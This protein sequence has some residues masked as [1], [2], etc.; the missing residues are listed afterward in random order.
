MAEEE[1]AVEPE[2]VLVD[3]S[4]KRK[5]EELEP[6]EPSSGDGAVGE[7]GVGQEADAENGNVDDVH[8]DESEAKRSRLDEG[9][10]AA[11]NGFEIE[12]VDNV[13]QEAG[14]SEGDGLEESKEANDSGS[15]ELAADG[16]QPPIGIEEHAEETAQEPSKEETDQEPSKEE[17]ALEPS[18]EETAQE[19]SK[20][21]S[22][23]ED[24]SE[25][26][27]EVAQNVGADQP[28][29][30]TETA[31][32][33]ME[34]PNN[35]VGVLIGKAGETIRYL[36]YNSGAKIQITRDAE[37]DR[38]S[39]SRSVELIG[40]L[41]CIAKAEKL[42]KDVIAEADAGGS[43]SLVARGFSTVQ[44]VTG[45][46]IEIQVPN[47]KVGLIIGKGGETIKNLQTT[48]GARIQLI[49]QHPPEG[50]QSEERTVRVTG[51]RKQI[52]IAREMIKEV[53]NQIW[54]MPFTSGQHCLG[55]AIDNSYALL[56]AKERLEVFIIITA[57]DVYVPVGILPSELH[58]IADKIVQWEAP[59]KGE[60]LF[61][62][63]C[64]LL[65]QFAGLG[66]IRSTNY[67]V[68][69]EM[70]KIS[71]NLDHIVRPSPL[72]GGHG[73]P[74]LR[75][76]GS[77][78]PQWGPQTALPSHFTGYD[79]HHR[80]GYPSQSQQY[81]PTYGNYPQSAP[82]GSYGPSWE[83]RPPVQ[84]LPPQGSYNYGQSQGSEYGQRGP[85][86][87][88][89][90]HGYNEGYSGP[91]Q[92]PYGAYGGS[93][94]TSYPTTGQYP[95]YGPGEQYGKPS[96]YGVP[97]QAQAY[98][99]PRAG[100]A[101][102]QGSVPPT[103]SYGSS[104][105]P[106]QSYPYG[107]GVP[108]QQSYPMYNAVAPADGYSQPQP[109]SASAPAY[110]QQAVPPATGYAQPGGQQPAVYGQGGA[111]SGYSSYPAQQG[112]AEQPA[113]AANAGYGYQ[114]QGDATYAA[115][116]PGSAAYAA[117]PAVQ[118]AYA[119]TTGTQGYDQSG[120]VPGGYGAPTPAPAAYGQ[121]Y[122]APR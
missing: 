66:W 110:T 95:G 90:G 77:L 64:S 112:Y 72:S 88:G 100:E 97:P 106:Q 28:D 76:R 122:A 39:T 5:L 9:G 105:P 59:E 45:D 32:R 25:S 24:G 117:Q 70:L 37:A 35:R 57:V 120:A 114:G 74:A 7:S 58:C 6:T 22:A 48:S 67:S 44:A 79:H 92:H 84:G 111:V 17:T 121:V 73:Q 118:A 14:L 47:E 49:P 54:I 29:G 86:P 1:L 87:R 8:K 36:Q 34:V 75:P 3:N 99:Q 83:Q 81:P 96:S 104:V 42:I 31:T 109:A 56:S 38:H 65:V 55:V 46:Q 2:V 68:F 60:A 27:A 115:T 113:A 108:V 52:E 20:E 63:A 61:F 19:P 78:A 101:P 10:H 62:K 119:P 91:Q 21:E 15:A 4:N 85:Y 71:A 23:K 51:D 103:Q 33:K 40:T 13:P 53:M 41:E 116:N 30:D 43:P 12:K 16:E 80:G 94:S 82:R 18:K 11:T 69:L 50:D 107:S 26:V 89:Y 93:Q 98:G 102:Y